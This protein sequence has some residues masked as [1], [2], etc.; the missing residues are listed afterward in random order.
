MDKPWGTAERQWIER[1]PEMRT[2]RMRMRRASADDRDAI[3]EIM[4]DPET[5]RFW[6]TPPHGSR[7]E[8]GRWLDSMIDADRSGLSDE[9][10]LEYEGRFIG[11][12]GAWQ[13]P[14]IGFFLHRDYWGRGLAAEAL[15]KFIVYAARRGHD[16]LTADVDPRNHSCL[17]LLERAGF[18]RTGM[19]Q[20]SYVVAGQA[21]DSLFLRRELQYVSIGEGPNP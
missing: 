11:K 1:T 10:I 15:Q 16:C 19:K 13:P 4:S 9:F 5:M 14:E 20:A 6:S 12:L 3:F 2:G 21:C 7:E 18:E 8:T 17:R